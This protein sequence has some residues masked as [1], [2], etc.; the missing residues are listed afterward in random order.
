[1]VPRLPGAC[2]FRPSISTVR[3]GMGT[4]LSDFSTSQSQYVVRVDS[5]G[6]DVLRNGNYEY[7]RLV[8]L[9][10]WLLNLITLGFSRVLFREAPVSAPSG[11][12]QRHALVIG[13]S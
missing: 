9:Y 6:A 10:F 11:Y 3:G 12:N 13:T 2:R 8:L 5:G 7:S 4:A 1:M